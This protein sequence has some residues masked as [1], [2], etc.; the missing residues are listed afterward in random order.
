MNANTF[1]GCL[2]GCLLAGTLDV[3][4]G[5]TPE[6]LYT[7]PYGLAR[8]TFDPGRSSLYSATPGEQAVVRHDL[9]GGVEQGRIPLMLSP[10]DTAVT[11]DGR[12]LFVTEARWT[13]EGFW[14]YDPGKIAEIDLESFTL[15]QEWD[16]P[17]SP[18]SLVACDDGILVVGDPSPVN[19]DNE[20]RLFNAATGETVGRRVAT[21]LS[22]T[23]DPSQQSVFCYGLGDVFQPNG[24]AVL[25]REPLG[26]GDVWYAEDLDMAAPVYPSPDGRLL[27]SGGS[28]YRG[29]PDDPAE[30]M[31]LLQRPETVLR[32]NQVTRFEPPDGRTFLVT[33]N[34]IGFFRRDTLEPFLELPLGTTL[35]AAYAGDVVYAVVLRSWEE[36]EVLRFPNP[37][38]GLWINEAPV[39]AFTWTPEN[40]TDAAEV[41]LDA[42]DTT[43]DAA[44]AGNLRFRWDF[45]SDGVFD[46]AFRDEPVVF[47]KFRGAGIQTV[48]LEVQD[49]FA[50]S[51]GVTRSFTVAAVPDVGEAGDWDVGGILP[52]P[53]GDLAFDPVRPVLYATEVVGPSLVRLDLLTGRITRKWWLDATP[54][55][56]AIRPDGSR[57]YLGLSTNDPA[58]FLIPTTGWIAEFDLEQERKER[59][60]VAGLEPLD[61]V[62]TATGHLLASGL[63][64]FRELRLYET[65]TGNARSSL[66]VEGNPQLTLHPG[67]QVC[68]GAVVDNPSVLERYWW[69]DETGL[70]NGPT[71]AS[72]QPKG[73]VYAL[74][75]GAH[76][77][78][79]SGKL[80]T[81]SP[82]P[83]EAGDMV[84]VRDLG[85]GSI[86]GIL[87]L[88]DRGLLGVVRVTGMWTNDLV[89][90]RDDL[91]SELV[92]IPV[93]YQT[94]ELAAYGDHYV[95]AVVTKTN[96][97]VETRRI[98]AR[99]VEENRPPTVALT[100]PI[101]GALVEVGDSVEL[102]AEA[103]DE[104]GVVTAV[105]FF[106]EAGSIGAAVI[107]HRLSW[108]P[109]GPGTYS[110]HAV[111]T[112]NLGVTGRSDT[113]TLIVNAL[114]TVT[115]ED[116]AGGAT[117]VSPATFTLEAHAEDEGGTVE[118]VEFFYYAYDLAMVSLGVVTEPPYR[119]TVT[120]FTGTDATIVAV[121]R[122]DLG[123]TASAYGALRIVGA[124][125]DDPRRPWLLEGAGGV[126][127]TNNLQATTQLE[128]IRFRHNSG[129]TPQHAL[130]WLWTAPGDGVVRLSTFGSSFDVQLT[131]LQGTPLRPLIWS[132]DDPQHS[133]A[134][135][136]K[137]PV[138]ADSQYQI[139]V[140]GYRAGH[141][142]LITL[143]P[144]FEAARWE[145]GE[146]PANDNL[147]D[148]LP[149]TGAHV[150]TT[151]TNRG[152][153]AEPGEPRSGL[154]ALRGPWRSVWWVWT[155]PST[156]G[157]RIST[158]G[159]DFDTQLTL[160]TEI[161][162]GAL[163]ALATNDDESFDV[164]TSALRLNAVQ[165]QVYY[166]AVDGIA[167]NTGNIALQLEPVD[168]NPPPNDD[169]LDRQEYS[170]PRQFV[171]GTTFGATFEPD[172]PET[173][174]TPMPAGHHTAW[175]SWRVPE[176]G[177]VQVIVRPDVVQVPMGLKIYTGESLETLVLIRNPQ[178][179]STQWSYD[180]FA[181][182]VA[183]AGRTYHLQV[184]AR[185]D[186][187]F[188]LALR[189]GFGEE[190]PRL[191]LARSG[192][193]SAGQLEVTS[194][195]WRHL[196]VRTSTDLLNWRDF[197]TFWLEGRTNL[198]VPPEA[199]PSARYFRAGA[200]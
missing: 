99:T 65:A 56:L 88:P 162:P 81:A 60:F 96:T 197:A 180:A 194:P 86:G 165:D 25:I 47:H 2:L 129:S 146:P 28:F 6:T 141:V 200:Y 193:P 121:A 154:V 186:V 189:A 108:K 192:E 113:V 54:G 32:L 100:S 18:R 118:E 24:R 156:G 187:D 106:S 29:A 122:D 112:D 107:P 184:F 130:W 33:G 42:G 128:E 93:H 62:A 95:L 103:S 61:M 178:P 35:D 135:E 36:V 49:R 22:L 71:I 16:Y 153:T 84:P 188:T 5:L 136:L 78:T 11:P 123:G 55:P 176:A 140:S 10:S 152:A 111:A 105:E 8:F 41:R 53:A 30:D 145:S 117:L 90:L 45:N 80:L 48:T 139:G 109:P 182:W 44:A 148:A 126:V 57:L 110:L 183:E 177:S 75:D 115:L 132:Q 70:L 120:D 27:V 83:G 159:S 4:A 1:R 31:T 168:G 38:L 170:G 69:D 149:L 67:Q 13:E 195:A 171:S 59:A 150:T 166:I 34:G 125:G 172:E 101:D 185:E 190:L 79:A 191:R 124:E 179:G 173:F 66:S 143:D 169:F 82:E 68:Y 198:V 63:S 164:E 161:A 17:F 85:L 76:L 89:F 158:R 181:D 7:L 91:E 15:V 92:R 167:G 73:P 94:R 37:S 134:S 19:G 98:P 102:R 175:Y 138:T 104:D 127:R 119:L 137:F 131:V 12:R 58:V 3:G 46:T 52:T 20:V 155:A 43:D 174:L 160:A 9:A 64:P 21:G 87:P 144:A 163:W 50:L 26:F 51:D 77:L 142:G 39:A 40:P 196:E 133:Y 14:T 97:W 151:G 74:P 114:P 116:P 147:A 72:E 23:L 157:Y 199:A